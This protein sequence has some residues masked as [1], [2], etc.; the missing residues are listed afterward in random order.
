MMF[1][2]PSATA[3]RGL[4]SWRA[5]TCRPL[6]AAVCLAGAGISHAEINAGQN[7]LTNGSATDP[8]ATGWTVISAGGDGWT[9]RGGGYDNVG[10]SF[11]TSFASSV[12]K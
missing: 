9:T 6:I 4:L 5:M 2:A 12:R 3:A 10:G 1:S 8:M 7:L 11:I